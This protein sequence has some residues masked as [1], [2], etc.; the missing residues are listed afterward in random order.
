MENSEAAA[1]IT[2]A[3]N[4]QA[5]ATAAKVSARVAESVAES[6]ERA[7]D[8]GIA[9]GVDKAI[10][11]IQTNEEQLQWQSRVWARL[12]AISDQIAALVSA[13][14]SPE[15]STPKVISVEPI[16]PIPTV[17]PPTPTLA[18]E[19]LTIP[20]E[21]VAP[22]SIPEMELPLRADGGLEGAEKP[23]RKAPR[24]WF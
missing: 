22:E 21:V 12:E 4:E 13:P 2:D 18:E 19:A 7:V 6:T 16:L 9:K 15:S 3:V 14:A 8:V 11:I 10:E 1:S 17:T 23:A 5:A 24:K 20:P